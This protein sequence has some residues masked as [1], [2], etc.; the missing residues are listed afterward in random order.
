MAFKFS[1]YMDDTSDH[2]D[3]LKIENIYKGFEDNT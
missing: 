1:F 2:Q 3:L